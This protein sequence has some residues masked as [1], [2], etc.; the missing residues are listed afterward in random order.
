MPSPSPG[1]VVAWWDGDGVAFGVVLGEEKQRVL[2]ITVEGREERITPSRI[3][4]TLSTGPAPLKTP[5]A[6]RE[7]SARAAA[8][9]MSLR[10]QV[11]TVD[12]PT[13]WELVAGPEVMSDTALAELALGARDEASRLATVLAL[14]KDGVRFARKT[15]GWQPRE[16]VAV[17]EI[18]TGRERA[19]QRASE[20]DALL[21]ALARAGRG[22]A[23]T[24]SGSEPEKRMLAALE[25]LAMNDL[26]TPE[27]ERA[28]AIEAIDAAAVRADRPGEGAFRVLRAIGRFASDDE[29]LGIARFGLRTEFPGDVV[30][31]AQAAAAAGFDRTGRR[32]LTSLA[33]VTID[34]P[35]TREI[36]DALTVTDGH[37]GTS[38]VGVHIADP[39]AFIVPGDAIDR[40]AR[41]RGTTYYFP[42]RKLLMMPSVLSEQAASLIAGEERPALSFLITVDPSGATVRSEIVRSV[43]RVVSRLD[44]AEVDTALE[45]GAGEHAE[46]LQRLHAIADARETARRAAGAVALRAPEAEIRVGPDGSMNVTQRDPETPAQR[47]V[48]EAMI[49]VGEVAAKWL[50]AKRFPAI[51]RRQAPPEG[52]LPEADTELPDAVHIRATRRM[53]KRAEASL[54]PAP[55]HGLGLNAYLQAT[56]PLRRY[57]DLA[58]H[59]QIVA[60]L[61]GS[62]PA[63]DTAAMQEILAATERSEIDGRRAERQVA[64]Y[65]MLRWLQGRQGTTVTG[66]VVDTHTRPIVV[67]DETLIETAVPSL[68]GAATG[69]RVRLRIERVNPRADL[70]VLR[71]V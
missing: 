10:K 68:V 70:I 3:A 38:V 31:A 19:A 17:A 9:A 35:Q 4:A 39:A 71:A 21:E 42:E 16:A 44:Y 55:H 23:F 6:R 32:D 34:D 13:L 66:V 30:E 43:I 59:R 50:E 24:P 49:L 20:K 5:E 2:V 60:G 22:E 63:Y 64:R 61:E 65:W 47:I 27:K 26:E 29:N 56:S 46:T 67:L 28:L 52:R 48:S 58:L 7:A 69:D 33:P 25:S 15:A 40:E 62:E 11:D 36:D 57:Q 37:G 18:L 54:H 8:T 1:S 41:L 12:V 45:A 51:F 53:L 14:A